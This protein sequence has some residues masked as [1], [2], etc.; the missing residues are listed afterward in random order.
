MGNNYN[1]YFKKNDNK[2][3]KENTND[4]I[5]S[6]TSHERELQIKPETQKQADSYIGVPPVN[7]PKAAVVST[8][9]LNVR[10]EPNKLSKVLCVLDSG[11]NIMVDNSDEDWAHVYTEHGVEGYVMKEY[12]IISQL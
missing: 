9:K 3:I 10:Q 7:K 1:K 6:G 5:F 12:I 4:K 11:T 2:D 8:Y